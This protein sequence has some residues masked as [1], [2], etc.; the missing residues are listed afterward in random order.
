MTRDRDAEAN[1]W[2]RRSCSESTIWRQ[3]SPAKKLRR[4]RLLAAATASG[5]AKGTGSNSLL[6]RRLEA[7]EFLDQHEGVGTIA[8]YECSDAGAKRPHHRIKLF[9]VGYVDY[10]GGSVGEIFGLVDLEHLKERRSEKKLADAG[11]RLPGGVVRVFG[12]G[13]RHY[14]DWVASGLRDFP[15]A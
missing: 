13:A 8:P 12:R 10:L 15:F 14:P 4:R 1:G 5:A 6:L 3:T 9:A 11:L 7:G 2:A